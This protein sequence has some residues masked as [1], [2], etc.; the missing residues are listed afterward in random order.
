[1]KVIVDSIFKDKNTGEIYNIGQELKIK[2]ERYKEI[3]DFVKIVKNDKKE[4]NFIKG[5]EN[6]R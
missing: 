1:M 6:A 5:E 4:M 3:K 2:R